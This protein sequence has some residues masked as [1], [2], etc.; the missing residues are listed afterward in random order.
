M[1]ISLAKGANISLEKEQPGLARTYIGLG[2]DARATD[3]AAFDLDASVFLLNGAGRVRSDLDFVFYGQLHG[4]DGAI[5]H[6]PDNLDGE[7][8]GDDEWVKVDLSRVPQDVEKIAVTVTIHD[9]EGRRQNFGMVQNAF[10][11][12]AVE[13][14]QGREI[15]RYDLAEDYSTET[16]IIFGELY[17]YKGEWKFRAVGQGYQG[18]L[19]ALCRSYGVNVG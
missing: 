2:W 16:A 13:D 7:G 8:D 17:R 3:G 18:G 4:L 19:A 1:S 12:I 11:R 6:S 9:S 10:V 15:T 14:E 5:E